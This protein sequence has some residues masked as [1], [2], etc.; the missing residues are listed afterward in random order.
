MQSGICPSG[1]VHSTPP[2]PD[3]EESSSMDTLE[4]FL[5]SLARQSQPITDFGREGILAIFHSEAVKPHVRG[6][7][8][9]ALLHH[10]ELLRQPE[11]RV[12]AA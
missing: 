4:T 2:T 11:R 12:E 8:L 1:S 5:R 3:I 6:L 10:R 9:D 7:A